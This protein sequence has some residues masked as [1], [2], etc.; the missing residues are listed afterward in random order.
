M[1]IDNVLILKEGQAVGRK[2]IL[3]LAVG[4]FVGALAGGA[5]ADILGDSP[6]SDQ[7]LLTSTQEFVP[8]GN[9]AGTDWQTSGPVE[10]VAIP[11]MV[12]EESWMKD[13]GN[14]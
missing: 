12:S 6:Q 11:V 8:E 3:M 7:V 4:A 13:Y 1:N 9:W 14:D 5:M 2:T 10:I